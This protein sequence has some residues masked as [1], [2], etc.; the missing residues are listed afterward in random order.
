[1]YFF[2]STYKCVPTTHTNT[3]VAKV[4]LDI[5]KEIAKKHLK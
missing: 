5:I 1:M 3:W 4:K 2:K